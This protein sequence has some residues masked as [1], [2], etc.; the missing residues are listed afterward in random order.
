MVKFVTH[1]TFSS[2]FSSFFIQPKQSLWKHIIHFRSNQTGERGQ[3]R[4]Q[5][6]ITQLNTKLKSTLTGASY[7]TFN[8]G[9]RPY[10]TYNKYFEFIFLEKGKILNSNDKYLII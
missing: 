8:Q 6:T 10:F 3:F 5:I 7:I 1:E 9:L 2:I 4:G